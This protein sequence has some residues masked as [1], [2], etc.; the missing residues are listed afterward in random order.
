M[1][2]INGY[3]LVEIL[4]KNEKLESGI[5]IPLSSVENNEGIIIEVD[6]EVSHIVNIGDKVV[7]N[8]NVENEYNYNGKLCKFL[9]VYDKDSPRTDIILKYEKQ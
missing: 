3:C 1:R 9:K 2:L 5:Y 7:Y 4:K 8:K 6:P